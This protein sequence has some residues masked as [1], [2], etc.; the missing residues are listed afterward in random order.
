MT[1]F[2]PCHCTHSLRR[3]SSEVRFLSSTAAL[4]VLS[5]ALASGNALARPWFPQPIKLLSSDALGLAAADLN[6]DGHVDVVVPGKDW[7]EI[8]VHLGNG[9]GSFTTLD[10]FYSVRFSSIR[11]A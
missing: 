6:N 3:P 8:W 5:A 10:G 1:S 7:D 9:D 4:L 2:D 11:V